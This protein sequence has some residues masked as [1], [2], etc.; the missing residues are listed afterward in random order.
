MKK[1]KSLLFAICALLFAPLAAN[2][3]PE[4]VLYYS[5]TCPHCHNAQEFIMQNLV[6]EYRS[7]VVAQVNVSTQSNA[8]EF[9]EAVKKCKLDSFG[10]P[11]VVIGEKCFQGYGLTTGQEYR[12]AINAELSAEEVA[13]ASESRKALDANPEEVRKAS[14]DRINAVQNSEKKNDGKSYVF[15]YALF[16]ILLIAFGF[17]ALSKKKKK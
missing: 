14:A 16:G 15:L 10:V 2:A 5:P 9:Q 3:A 8:N 7:L 12:E 11:L 4:L 13:E 6:I 17:V 1:T